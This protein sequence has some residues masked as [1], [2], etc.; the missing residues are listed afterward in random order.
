MTDLLNEW[1]LNE[2]IGGQIV[3]MVHHCSTVINRLPLS[4]RK[5]EG[6]M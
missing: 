3:I 1:T 4:E 2:T 6:E 5:E